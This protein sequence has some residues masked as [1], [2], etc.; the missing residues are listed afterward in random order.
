MTNENRIIFIAPD[1]FNAVYTNNASNINFFDI[2]PQETPYH[3]NLIIDNLLR[4]DIFMYIEELYTL[5]KQFS[6]PIFPL[7]SR[8]EKNR[9][10]IELCQPVHTSINDDCLSDFVRKLF[11]TKK[12]S[13]FDQFLDTLYLDSLIDYYAWKT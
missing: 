4:R 11:Q 10:N 8:L 7:S 3:N 5:S 1:S 12:S 13:Y 2:F 6:L 9:V